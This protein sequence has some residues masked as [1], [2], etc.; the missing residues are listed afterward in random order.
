MGNK[1]KPKNKIINYSQGKSLN[2][3]LRG[4]RLA[5]GAISLFLDY[6]QG[7]TKSEEGKLRTQRKVEYLKIYLLDNPKTP[8]ERH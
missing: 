6:Y 2:V 4:K 1:N 7:Y 8:D 5:N 3:R